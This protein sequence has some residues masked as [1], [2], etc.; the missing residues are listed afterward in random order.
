MYS[1]RSVASDDGVT[2]LPQNFTGMEDW[3]S[4]VSHFES[5][6]TI[7]G[8]NNNEKLMWMRVKLV[9]KAAIA[10]E[11]LSHVTK[12][13][14]ELAKAALRNRF[15]H[16]SKRE[17]YKRDFSNRL[18]RD[19]ENWADYGDDLRLLV[20]RAYPDLQPNAQEHLALRHYLDQLKSPLIAVGVKQ[21]NPKTVTEAVEITMQLES[22]LP[23]QSPPTRPQAEDSLLLTTIQSSQ[24]NILE[25]I[26]YLTC[27]VDR[28]E[29][30]AKESFKDQF[31]PPCVNAAEHCWSGSNEGDDRSP[32]NPKTVH[33]ADSAISDLATITI[34]SVS[35]Y[36]LPVCVA[37]MDVSCLVDTGAGVSLLSGNVLDKIDQRNVIME[38]VCQKLVGVDGIPLKVRGASTFHFIIA[39]L[40]FNHRLIIADNITADA[41]LGLDFLDSHQ[42]VLDLGQRKLCVNNKACVPLVPHLTTKA[43]L[44]GKLVLQDTTVIPP[45]SELEVMGRIEC[46][47]KQD[48]NGI[49]WMVEGVQ[50]PVF[51]ARAI[52][53]PQTKLVPV[54]LINT[55][56]IP[57]T[58]YRGTKLANAETVDERNVDVVGNFDV[59]A[60]SGTSMPAYADSINRLPDDVSQS[61]QDKFLALLSLYSDVI[62]S[63]PDDLGHTQVLSHHIDTGDAPPIRQ[64]PLCHVEKRYSN[65]FRIC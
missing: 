8:W 28:L 19:A 26:Q 41:I 64:A 48:I 58:L 44:C 20:E 63:G 22:Y 4:W 18:K 46:S 45:A 37:G 54:R 51:V 55:D 11:Q 61:Q 10:F 32:A 5:I 65:Y 49:T 35:S 2:V 31:P 29:S 25:Q 3:D 59:D 34:N 50:N 23:K 17:L 6:S 38:P 14:Y 56:L 9:D 7:H 42:C 27:Q 39:G 24:L 57:V 36:F 1:S 62:A 47:E 15:E 60:H 40:E 13:S 21:T 30:I 52:V 43:S 53:T 12:A 33:E 16:P